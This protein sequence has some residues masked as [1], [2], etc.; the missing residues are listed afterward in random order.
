MI[1]SPVGFVSSS[2]FRRL[3]LHVGAEYRYFL[4]EQDGQVPHPHY[5]VGASAGTIANAACLPWTDTNFKKV[6]NSIRYLKKSDMFDIPTEMKLVAGL[7]IAESFSGLIHVLCPNLSRKEKFLI[8]SG[9]TLFSLVAKAGPLYE[10]F[11]R[12]PSI[13]SNDRL[14]RFL[15]NPQKGLDFQGIWNSDIRMEIPSTNIITGKEYIFDLEA[16]RKQPDQDNRLVEALLASASLPAHFPLIK[17]DHQLL[18]DAAILN[19]IPI[20][21]AIIADCQTIFVLL[22]VTNGTS[23][24][25]ENW[26]DE[27]TRALDISMGE[28]IR[29]ELSWQ[30]NIS[31]YLLALKEAKAEVKSNEEVLRQL[32]QLPVVSEQKERKEFLHE[33]LRKNLNKLREKLDSL[34][35]QDERPVTIIPVLSEVSIPEQYFRKFKQELMEE[36]M[37]LGYAA[38]DKTL[39][40]L[41]E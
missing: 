7:S 28:I 32:E 11:L 13:Y 41:E 27:L 37:N 10:L 39:K 21:R 29:R 22:Y 24:P 12:Q 31:P 6:A 17:L 25:I 14:R 38:M 3:P 15:K 18:D 20:K 8:E 40:E 36:A 30:L 9:R 19:G 34:P 5:M 2:G 23:F 33:K 1:R 35:F 16:N 4:A 26:V